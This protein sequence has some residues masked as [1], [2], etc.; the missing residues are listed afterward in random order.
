[1]AELFSPDGLTI[2]KDDLPVVS[3]GAYQAQWAQ[4]EGYALAFERVPGGF[5]PGGEAAWE[6]LPEDLCQCPHWGYLVKGKALL[7]MA[8]GREVTINGG[9]LYYAPPG[10]KLYAI[11][12][13]E[14]IE[15]NPAKE[16]AD[17][18]E[19]FSTNIKKVQGGA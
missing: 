18:I 19:A 15:F 1:M 10:H 16:A 11:E 12:D 6:G 14:N 5:P 8:D 9:D 4:W 3:M 17:T 2:A 13:F 7:R